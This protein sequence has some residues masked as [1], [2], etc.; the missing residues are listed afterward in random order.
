M[1]VTKEK[2]TKKKK[3]IRELF[4]LMPEWEAS[5]LHLKAGSPPIYRV[6][7]KLRRTKAAPLDEE[8]IE[9]MVF[10]FLS[11]RQAEILREKG[12]VD[13]GYDIS[14]GRVRVNA[15]YQRG[16]LGLVGRLIETEIPS[17]ES[18]NLPPQLSKVIEYSQ[19]LVL[20]C[21]VTGSGKSTTLA[22]LL[23]MVNRKYQEHI[24]TIEDPIEFLHED[25]KCIVN[26]REMGLDCH[27]WP[28]ALAAAMREDPDV[29]LVG[30]MRDTETFQAA[31]TA[32]ETGHLVF[33]TMH[34]SS[35]A[36]TIPRILDLFPTSKHALIRQS[37]AK[38]LN[39]IIGQKLLPSCADDIARV[40]VVEYMI[41]NP[42]IRKA[43]EE[44]DYEKITGLIAEGENEGMIT[45][46]KS[47][48]DMI[49][50][51]LID[52]RTA[53]RYAP[54]AEKVEMALKGIEVSTSTLND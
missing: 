2:Q 31:L 18:L 22:S 21:G 37:L 29:I 12:H 24:L 8:D 15:F 20:V 17:L 44:A 45:W 19:G 42:S 43:I 53:K 27:D 10:G 13:M 6:A 50:A 38:N 39:A 47:F 41:K 4:D 3:S 9:E 49:N 5:D 30:E 46:T 35:A 51:D 16:K 1:S 34:T 52:K 7:G 40:P 28:E 54:N 14:A 36:G 25:K 33:G 11:E 48:V 32:S 23:D 26:Q